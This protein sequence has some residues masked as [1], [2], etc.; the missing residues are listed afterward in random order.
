[1]HPL[2]QAFRRPAHVRGGMGALD[3]RD[4]AIS[5]VQYEVIRMNHLAVLYAPAPV[6]LALFSSA[7]GCPEEYLQA[8]VWELK[9]EWLLEVRNG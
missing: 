8:A 1:M 2:A 5:L 7:E 3:R 6:I 9:K 4:D